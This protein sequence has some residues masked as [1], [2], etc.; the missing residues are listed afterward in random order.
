M[1]R[2][3][4]YNVYELDNLEKSDI[5]DYRKMDVSYLRTLVITRGLVSDTKKLKKPDLIRILEEAETEIKTEQ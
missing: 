5:V 2:F 3:P 1:D 4:T